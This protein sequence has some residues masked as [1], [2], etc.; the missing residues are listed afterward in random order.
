MKL[1]SITA[2]SPI[3]GRYNDKV[4]ELRPI[5][6]E[7]GLIYYRL[8]VEIKWLQMLS[9]NKDITEIQS[10]DNKTNSFLTKLL[11]DFNEVEAQR[12]KEIEESTNHDVK[13]IEYYLKEKL[14]TK[15]ELNN[16]LEFVHFCCTSEDINNLSYALM[17]REGINKILISK[18]DDVIANL[19]QMSKKYTDISMLSFTH[20]QP[21]SP[22]TIGKEL[23]NFVDRLSKQRK[24]IIDIKLMGKMNGAVGNYN[25]HL[26]AYPKINWPQVSKEFIESLGIYYNP[27]TTQIEPHDYMAE[28]F[29]A[30]IRINNI[31]IDFCRDIWT[32]ISIGYFKQKLLSNEVGSS[33]MPHKVN[34]IDFENAEGNLGLA[35][36]LYSHLSDKLAISRLQ[37]DLSDSTVLRNIGVGFSYMLIALKSIEKGLSKLEVNQQKISQDLDNC[38]EILAEPIQTIMRKNGIKNPYEKLKE[39]TR[40]N[41]ITEAALKEFID[42]LELTDNIKNELKKLK[43]NEYIGNASI[44]V[45]KYK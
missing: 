7:Y 2:I 27:Y 22:T 16:S 19:T 38:W 41:K 10:F 30:C 18:L 40:G 4:A 11:D 24:V 6:S 23:I 28:I 9:S 39:F 26:L 21:A 25:A 14:S 13:A 29:H 1:Q 37:R 34:P 42:Q 36:A 32:Y 12:I 8:A 33:T 20:G 44:I 3:D 15:S 45:K 35:N 43:P 5:F 31:L 17:L